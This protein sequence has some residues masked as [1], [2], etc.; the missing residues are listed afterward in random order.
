MKCDQQ[1]GRCH[2]CRE[3]YN[4]SHCEFQNPTTYNKTEVVT[5]SADSKRSKSSTALTDVFIEDNKVSKDRNNE[6]DR[7]QKPNP[8]GDNECNACFITS[9]CRDSLRFKI[10]ERKEKSPSKESSE[11]G[12]E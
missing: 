10:K 4:G 3:G 8:V 12:V 9:G 2:I 7:D 5:I 11:I 1:T 6:G